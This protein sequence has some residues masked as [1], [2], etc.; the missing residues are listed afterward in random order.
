M[1]WLDFSSYNLSNKELNEKMVFGAG[2]G[3]NNGIEFGVEGESCLRMNLACP[4]S[5]IESALRRIRKA[6]GE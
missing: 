2:V 3:M 6:F 4:R 1:L 5:V